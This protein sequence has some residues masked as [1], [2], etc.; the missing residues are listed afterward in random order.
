MSDA[1]QKK[2]AELDGQ[3]DEALK[4]FHQIKAALKASPVLAASSEG[5]RLK[6]KQRRIADKIKMLRKRIARLQKDGIYDFRVLGGEG[7]VEKDGEMAM[8]VTVDTSKLGEAKPWHDPTFKKAFSDSIAQWCGD[9]RDDL[10]DA[11]LAMIKLK[12]SSGGDPMALLNVLDLVAA[13]H[14]ASATAISVAKALTSLGE[15]AF[16]QALKTKNPS[17]VELADASIAYIVAIKD[18]DHSKAFDELVKGMKKQGYQGDTVWESEFLPECKD[19][20]K[21]YFGPTNNITKQFLKKCIGATEDS[22]DWDGGRAGFA[23]CWMT[24][25]GDA[26]PGHFGSPGGQLD[27]VHEAIV[28]SVKSVWR[29]KRVIDLPVEIRVTLKTHMGAYETVA[30]RKSVKPG[31]T[32]FRMTSGTQSMFDAW[33]KGRFY[34]QIKVSDL[35]VDG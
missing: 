16:K 12:E 28:A 9:A 21:N 19:F 34:E 30:E 31:D 20:T 11:R 3:I 5:R 26:S 23:D 7:F 1:A 29:G 2:W 32:S 27:D 6:E 15:A 33:M 8:E 17:V 24:G 25:V 13:A 35:Q 14:P 22:M 10:Q 18:G 4:A